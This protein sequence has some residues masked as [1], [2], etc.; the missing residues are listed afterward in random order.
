MRFSANQRLTPRDVI[1]VIR[2]LPHFGRMWFCKRGRYSIAVGE[3]K[4][5]L[6]VLSGHKKPPQRKATGV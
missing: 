2:T 3:R 6:D 5:G 4:H 1:S